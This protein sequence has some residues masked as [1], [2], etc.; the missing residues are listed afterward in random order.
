VVLITTAVV[1]AVGI[2][3]PFSPMAPAIHLQPL[4]AGF[5]VYVPLVLLAYCALTQ[6]VKMLYL[7]RFKSWL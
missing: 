2:W 7:R 5:F 6:L 4:P 1:M 3:L